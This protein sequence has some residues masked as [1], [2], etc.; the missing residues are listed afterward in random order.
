MPSTQAAR[1][2]PL[3]RAR[4]VDLLAP[5]AQDLAEWRLISGRPSGRPSGKGLIFPTMDG[6]EWKRHDWQNWRRRAYQPAAL[7]AGVTGDLRPYRLRGSF[8]SLLLWEGRSLAYV[9]EQ[10]R[11]LDCLSEKAAADRTG[12]RYGPSGR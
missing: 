11:A 8:V 1:P 10:G 6:D 12:T 4:D 9:A 2:I 5:L 3:F 7:A